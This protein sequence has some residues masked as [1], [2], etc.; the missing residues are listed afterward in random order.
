MRL[1]EE[2]EQMS[3]VQE[4]NLRYKNLIYVFHLGGVKLHPAV[5]AKLKRL[6]N[7]KGHPD[8]FAA[9]PR[10]DYHGCYIEYKRTGEK[11]KKKNG[12]WR[13]DHIAHQGKMLQRLRERGYY[14]EFAI[15]IDD[16]FE[17]FDTYMSL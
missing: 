12:D 4:L 6:G 14:A 17:K 13:N 9:E 3:I 2:Q 11:L 10:G 1:T 16:F 5:A 15:G 8:F 7:L